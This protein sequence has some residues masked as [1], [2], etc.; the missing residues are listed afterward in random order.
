MARS[1]AGSVP[2]A[3]RARVRKR[4]QLTRRAAALEVHLEEALLGVQ[5]ARRPGD[6]EP[7]PAADRWDAESVALDGHRLGEPLYRQ[8]PLE[9]GEA[10]AQLNADPERHRAERGDD[11]PESRRQRVAELLH[12][13]AR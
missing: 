2:E 3:R 13:V 12:D 6:V 1:A 9:H 5:E 8:R 4:R 7:I 11:E 10:A